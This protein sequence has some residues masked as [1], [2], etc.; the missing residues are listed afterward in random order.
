MNQGVSNSPKF[1]PSTLANLRY[2]KT[3]WSILMNKG[4]SNSPQ[5]MYN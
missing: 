5:L 2:A 3:N 1:V 4:A